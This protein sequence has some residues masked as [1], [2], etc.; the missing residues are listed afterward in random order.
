MSAA[1]R[2][3]QKQGLHGVVFLM[4]LLAAEQLF[5]MQYLRHALRPCDFIMC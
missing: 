5:V 2:A 3:L 4:L 1:E